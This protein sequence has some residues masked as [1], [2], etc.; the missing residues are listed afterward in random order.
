MSSESATVI[1]IFASS[2]GVGVAS[3]A[4]PGPIMAYLIDRAVEAGFGAALLVFAGV[5]VVDAFVLAAGILGFAGMLGVPVFTGMTA[6]LGGAFLTWSGASVLRRSKSYSLR[7]KA[8]KTEKGSAIKRASIHPLLAGVVVT[9]GNPLYWIWW[10]TVG[11]GYINWTKGIGDSAL[12]SFIAGMMGGVILFHVLIAYVFARGRKFISDKFYRSVVAIS[13]LVL[14]GF[15][16]FFV[17]LG[18]KTLSS[19]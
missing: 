3:S 6:L 11:L 15:G 19:L 5:L 12:I 13:G 14:T 7:G 16:L 2:F 4:L 10:A 17:F 1:G 8:V 9:V 18:F